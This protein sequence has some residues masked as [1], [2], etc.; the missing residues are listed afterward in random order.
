MAVNEPNQISL[1][2]LKYITVSDLLYDIRGGLY[3]ML[4]LFWDLNQDT[5]DPNVGS[6]KTELI[7]LQCFVAPVGREPTS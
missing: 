4:R 5:L 3:S 7:T 6:L 1:G 2:Q